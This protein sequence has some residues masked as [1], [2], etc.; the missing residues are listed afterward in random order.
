MSKMVTCPCCNA[1]FPLEESF[2]E[3]I[4]KLCDGTRTYKE[5]AAIVGCHPNY[6][7]SVVGRKKL[8][9]KR[10]TPEEANPPKHSERDR[11]IHRRALAGERK[12]NLAREFGLSYTRVYEIVEKLERKKRWEERKKEK[13][14]G[15][16][17]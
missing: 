13:E 9:V 17:L 4:A 7:T 11:E 10:L 6:V 16:R 3:K 14:N 5:I 12:L 1:T 8:S 2:A 15:D